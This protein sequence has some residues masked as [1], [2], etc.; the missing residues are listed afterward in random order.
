MF[1]DKC[2]A[3][4]FSVMILGQTY[5]VRRY[6]GTWLFPAC[7]FGL[8]WFAY[9]FIPL[10]VLFWMP[11][12]PFAIG[13]I[14]LCTVAVS[15]GCLAFDWK[16]AVARNG[17]RDNTAALVYGNP[18]LMAA[19][20][21][22]TLSSLIFLILNSSAQ[23]FSLSDLFYNFYASAESYAVMRYSESLVGNIFNPLSIVFAY[24]GVILGG[25]LFPLA[26]T[27]KGRWLI[28]VLSFLPSILV[29]VTQSAK[30]FLFLSVAF[31]YAGI[32]VYRVSVGKFCLIEKGS[33]R[34]LALSGLTLVSI[35]TISFLTRGL[36]TIQNGDE[37]LDTLLRNFASYSCSHIY[38]FSDWFSF[39]IGRHSELVYSR[40]GAAHGF[41]TFAALFKLMGSSRVLPMGG[42]DDFYS[43]GDIQPGNIFT[44]FRGLIQDFGL[45]GTVLFLLVMSFLLHWAFHSMLLKRR[46]VFTVTVFI[47]MVGYFYLSFAI[48][49]LIWNTIYAAFVLT[50]MVLQVNK[51]ILQRRDHRLGTSKLPASPA[52]LRS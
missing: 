15:W 45:V 51:L 23:G 12:N 3:L 46:P 4:V 20:Y 27:R 7:I 5:L 24:L 14:F 35:V 26:P 9:T 42:F 49:F 8:F 6:V 37:L 25:L 17:Q 1:F 28:I 19:F 22:A 29:A 39:V 32:L 34:S 44:M 16:T 40:E 52:L 48:S 31:F 33:I 13:F 10:T 47:F 18:F 30:G 50:W 21:V 41:Y 43:H 11:V 2:L 38:A 36:Y